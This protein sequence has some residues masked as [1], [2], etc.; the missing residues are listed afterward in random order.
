MLLEEYFQK[1]LKF[2]G[3][4]Y[5]L[6]K[7]DVIITCHQGALLVREVLRELLTQFKHLLFLILGLKKFLEFL[8]NDN[9]NDTVTDITFPLGV[10]EIRKYESHIE[11]VVV[12]G[13]PTQSSSQI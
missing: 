8:I 4:V 11:G 6:C 12:I 5:V 1:I 13:C 7:V 3:L 2:S 10:E 9:L